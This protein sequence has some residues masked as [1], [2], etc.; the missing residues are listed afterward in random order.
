MLRR[1]SRDV[2]QKLTVFHADGNL[3]NSWHNSCVSS[4]Q[5]I[6]MKYIFLDSSKNGEYADINIIPQRPFFQ[7]AA[8]FPDF[9]I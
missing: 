3:V 5:K 7:K 9:P 4:G 6:S 1:K 2:T 8:N